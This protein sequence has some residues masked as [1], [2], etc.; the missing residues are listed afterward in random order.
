M[1]ATEERQIGGYRV[2]IDRLLCVGFGDCIAEAPDTF[3][4]DDEGVV[5]FRADLGQVSEVALL[6][7][8]ASCPVDALTVFDDT[9]AQIIP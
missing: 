7:A 1:A 2:V 6:D 3:E 8:C 9:G 5:V 4:F